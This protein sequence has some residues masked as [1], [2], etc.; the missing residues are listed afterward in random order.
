MTVAQKMRNKQSYKR[1]SKLIKDV[2]KHICYYCGKEITT[3]NLSIDHAIPLSRGGTNALSNLRICC[4][5]CNFEKDNKTEYEY[6]HNLNP[7]ELNPLKNKL[8]YNELID[9]DSIKIP[10]LFLRNHVT[11]K[12]LNKVRQYYKRYKELD[13]PIILTASYNRYLSD[14]Y[15]RYVVAK[16]LGL[17]TVPVIYE[18]K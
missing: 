13:K 2:C 1:S 7:F 15:S 14:G 8:N 6:I 16:E 4:K 11:E 5:Q 17:K 18:M 3:E 9:I 10:K 12:K